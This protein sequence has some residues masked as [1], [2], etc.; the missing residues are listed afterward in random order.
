MGQEG[1][2]L[3]CEPWQGGKGVRLGKPRLYTTRDV[4][5]ACSKDGLALHPQAVESQLAHRWPGAGH[6]AW[7]GPGPNSRQESCR[8]QRAYPGSFG[9]NVL[10]HMTVGRWANALTGGLSRQHGGSSVAAEGVALV[11]EAQQQ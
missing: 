8:H 5:Q 10:R 4:F 1:A 3:G 6:A 11:G 2:L 7:G 9:A